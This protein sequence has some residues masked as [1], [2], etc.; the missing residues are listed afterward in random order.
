MATTTP[1]LTAAGVCP[2]PTTPVE[3]AKRIAARQAIDEWVTDGMVLGVGSGSTILYAIQ[4]L[5]EKVHDEKSLKNICCVPT[6]FQSRNVSRFM[7]Y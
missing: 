5:V 7:Q 1:R 4:R 6:S 2:L 3:Q